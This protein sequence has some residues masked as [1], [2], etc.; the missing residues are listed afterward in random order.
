MHPMRQDYTGER[1]GHEGVA[2]GPGVLVGAESE[3]EEGYYAIKTITG[4]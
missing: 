3:L 2:A 4:D 1:L